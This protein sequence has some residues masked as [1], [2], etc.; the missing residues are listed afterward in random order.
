MKCKLLL[1][2]FNRIQFFFERSLIYIL[3]MRNY[4]GNVFIYR[5]ISNYKRKGACA[6][7]PQLLI[8]KLLV[9]Y[10]IF[11]I[12]HIF[13]LMIFFFFFLR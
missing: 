6:P 12:S 9:F 10:L 7:H 1:S 13:L 5:F 8:F 4:K 2:I 3:G 11:K